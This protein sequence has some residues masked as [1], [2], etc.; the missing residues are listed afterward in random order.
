MENKRSYFALRHVTDTDYAGYNMPAWLRAE[1]PDDKSAAILD[2]GCGLGQLLTALGQAGYENFEGVDQDPGALARCREQKLRVHAAKTPAQ[3]AAQRKKKFDRIIMSHV[4]EH[5][6]PEQIIPALTDIRKRLLSPEG[7]LIVM[8]PNAQARSGAYW[9]YED[10]THRTIFTGG[11]LRFVLESAGF[12]EIIFPDITG[13]CGQAI[14]KR[15]L[16]LAGLAVYRFFDRQ[17]NRITGAAWHKSSP[18]IL[19]W[20]V[21]AVACAPIVRRPSKS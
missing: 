16:R 4:L 3:F 12:C 21:K 7:R 18:H 9:R 20:E 1:L 10:F 19:T 15:L 6:P 13:T 17:L 14:H 8:V 2:Y 11:S 5:M